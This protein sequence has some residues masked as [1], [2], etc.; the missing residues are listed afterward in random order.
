[1]GNFKKAQSIFVECILLKT[2]PRFTKANH[3]Y[4][5]PRYLLFKWLGRKHEI[6]KHRAIALTK[7]ELMT[8]EAVLRVLNH[9]GRNKYLFVRVLKSNLEDVTTTVYKL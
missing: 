5:N 3:T 8:L 2:K 1:M 4:G 9:H 7:V 6:R